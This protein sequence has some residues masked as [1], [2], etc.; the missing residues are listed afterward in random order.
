M[1][2]PVIHARPAG[3]DAAARFAGR[4]DLLADLLGGTSLLLALAEA[5]AALPEAL[6]HVRAASGMIRDAHR[7]A[8]SVRA[9]GTPGGGA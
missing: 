9:E 8:L 7:V 5:S 2:D 1:S 6:V 4:T 3:A